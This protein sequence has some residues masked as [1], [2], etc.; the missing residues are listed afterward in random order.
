MHEQRTI[1]LFKLLTIKRF[2]R[3]TVLLR[4]D[5]I[6]AEEFPCKFATLLSQCGHTTSCIGHIVSD[7][8]ISFL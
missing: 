5:S 3:I 6:P 2:S 8:R 4:Q 1:A 7:R